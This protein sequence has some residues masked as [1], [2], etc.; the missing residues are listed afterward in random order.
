MNLRLWRGIRIVP[1]VPGVVSEVMFQ[2]GFF[3]RAPI[4]YACVPGTINIIPVSNGGEEVR[5]LK[6]LRARGR[7]MTRTNLDSDGEQGLSRPS[8]DNRGAL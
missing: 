8:R 3:G 7:K 4:S 5:F 2:R 1:G 6:Q